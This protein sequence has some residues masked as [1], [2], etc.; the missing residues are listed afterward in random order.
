MKLKK[1]VMILLT[2]LMLLTISSSVTASGITPNATGIADTKEDAITL[3]N[4]TMYSLFISDANDQDWYK[5]TNDTG[6]PRQLCG[7][8][9]PTA[10]GT[11]LNLAAVVDYGKYQ[12]TLLHGER[13]VP[14]NGMRI[15]NLYVPDG[16]TIYF[17][18]ANDLSGA[19][20]Y[21]F[22]ILVFNYQ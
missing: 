5:W 17:R 22:N 3:F 18:I 9:Y 21:K 16:A 1:V 14:T 10:P 2:S 6:G 15:E 11:S 7:Y 8:L 19:V 13:N 12:T 4:N 20:Q